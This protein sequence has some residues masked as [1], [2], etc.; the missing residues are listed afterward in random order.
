[1]ARGEMKIN[2]SGFEVNMTEQQLQGAQV[3]PI[4]Q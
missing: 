1:M 4:F 2:G 3:G